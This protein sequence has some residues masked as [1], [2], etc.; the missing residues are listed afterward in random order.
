MFRLGGYHE[1]I[2]EIRK[3]VIPDISGNNYYYSVK[4]LNLKPGQYILIQDC[5]MDDKSKKRPRLGVYFKCCHI[6]AHIYL[7]RAGN[8][9]VGWCPKCAAKVEMKVSPNGS[10][11]KIFTAE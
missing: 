9:F 10:T 5:V 11:S 4:Q 6:Y 3:N 7:N 1:R 2:F 8:A